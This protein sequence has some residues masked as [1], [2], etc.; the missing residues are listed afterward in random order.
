VLLAD[1]NPHVAATAAR[2]LL[3]LGPPGEATLRETADRDPTSASAA[4][5]RAALD[6][7]AVGGARLD[8][9]VEVTQ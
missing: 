5:A 1:E 3:R 4:H 7:A 9:R 8:L 2:A 6:E